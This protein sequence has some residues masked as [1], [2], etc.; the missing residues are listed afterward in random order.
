VIARFWSAQ[1]TH[2]QAPVYADHLRNEVLPTVRTV[3][4]YA[5]AMLLEREV[6]GGIEILVITFW[7]SLDSIRGFA[8]DDL[9]GAVV[10]NEIVSL[11]SQFDQRVRHYEL[12]L[13]DER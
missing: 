7:R 13:K 1:T 12:I 10:S 2:A 5:G 3:D 6:S 4:G 8:G 11:F 9:E